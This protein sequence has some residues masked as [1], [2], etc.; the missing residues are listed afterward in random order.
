MSSVSVSLPLASPLATRVL[1]VSGYAPELHVQDLHTHLRTSMHLDAD[2]Y[3]IQGTERSLVY[4]LF[5]E[6]RAAKRVYLH[7]LCTPPPVLRRD[8]TRAAPPPSQCPRLERTAYA[9]VRPCTG[10]EAVGLLSHAGMLPAPPPAPATRTPS[11]RKARGDPSNAAY[12]SP[13]RHTHEAQH[14]TRRV[15]S[16]S[17]LPNKPAGGPESA[18]GRAAQRTPPAPGRGP[19]P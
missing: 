5:K 1:A 13:R 11:G 18:A 17:G 6:P 15:P 4:L 16:Y 7:W 3:K 12:T 19:L 14:G 2:A 10:P 8:Y 9:N